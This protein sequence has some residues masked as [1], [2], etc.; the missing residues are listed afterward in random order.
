VLLGKIVSK[1]YELL[2]R[3][4]GA[5]AVPKVQSRSNHPELHYMHQIA[6]GTNHVNNQILQKFCN[7][8]AL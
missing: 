3:P 5:P 6:Y 8:L 1:T 7:A 2:F 4:L